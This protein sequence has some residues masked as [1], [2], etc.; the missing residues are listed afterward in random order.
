MTAP[1]IGYLGVGSNIDPAC[2]VVAALEQLSGPL[3]LTSV[4]T[5]YR[6][7]PVDR[8]DQPPFANGVFG[9]ETSLE[10]RQLKQLLCAVE[11]K[12]GRRRT[13]DRHSPRTI[14]LDLLLLGELVLD[15]DR[16]RL[17]DPD[18]RRRPFIS[19]PL[20]ELA[21]ELVLPDTGERLSEVVGQTADL[22]PDAPLTAALRAALG[23][24]PGL[25]VPSGSS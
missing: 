14:D 5:F 2:N 22:T 19:T 1:R 12:L 25:R 9:I 17:P 21:P 6:T 4:S 24:P 23:D 13:A 20:L 18:I 7:E 10:P 16:F 15:D 11:V 3:T 8:P